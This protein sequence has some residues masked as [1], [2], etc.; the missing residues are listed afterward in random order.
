[1]QTFKC[2]APVQT[3]PFGSGPF[4]EPWAVIKEKKYDFKYHDFNTLN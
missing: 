4:V 3:T 1:M 2:N